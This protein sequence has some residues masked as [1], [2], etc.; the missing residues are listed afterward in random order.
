[1]S[2]SLQLL[3]NK[4]GELFVA[5]GT[6]LVP[7][8]AGLAA[9]FFF[10]Y[11]YP[12]L[13]DKIVTKTGGYLEWM[14]TH[15]DRMFIKV[16]R[17]TCFLLLIFSTLTVGLLGFIMTVGSGFLN[18]VM[19][20]SSLYIGWSLPRLLI[21]FFWKR[22]LRSFDTQ[23]VD[24]L[25]LMANSV[26]SGLNLLQIIQL[27]VQEMPDPISQEFQLVLN[28]HHLGVSLDE[29]LAKML[30]RVPTED[31]A[32]AINAILILRET[33]GDLSETFAVISNTIRE[34][35]KI[36]GKIKAIT[37]QGVTQSVILFLLP[38]GIALLIHLTN[39]EY[40]QPLFSNTWGYLFIT[41]MLGLQ[42]VGGIWLKKLVTIDV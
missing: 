17:R 7:L 28:Q 6:L 34:R 41:L 31:L 23:L 40:L 1:M 30:E 10:L 21:G 37:A 20:F 4:Y 5:Y 35:R 27:V 18:F 2:S 15:L 8:I 14:M 25:A 32:M 12:I 42:L 3:I 16:T 19:T 26:K 39:P 24:G 9:L 38:F 13:D 29:A 36:E 22:R 11:V 33:G